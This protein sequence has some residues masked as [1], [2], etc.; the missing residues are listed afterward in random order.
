ME[1]RTMDRETC[2][3][4]LYRFSVQTKK[5]KHT[6]VTQV[7][8]WKCQLSMSILSNLTFNYM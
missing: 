7:L 5:Q 3:L 4:G 2:C 1:H 6:A 8:S